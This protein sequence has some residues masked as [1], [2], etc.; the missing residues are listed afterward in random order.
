MI[1]TFANIASH[2]HQIFSC[3]K[4]DLLYIIYLSR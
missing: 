4:I 1:D 3:H 2:L